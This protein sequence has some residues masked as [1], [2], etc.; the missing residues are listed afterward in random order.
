MR[1]R[2]LL[3]PYLIFYAPLSYILCPIILCSM[4]NYFML[5]A[6]LFYGPR[7]IIL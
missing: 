3:T 6:Q 4:P 5:Y 1:S 2:P 7:I